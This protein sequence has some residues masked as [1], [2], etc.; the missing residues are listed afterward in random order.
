MNWQEWKDTAVKKAREGVILGG[1][2]LIS[3]LLIAIFQAVPSSVWGRVSE[4][5]PKPVLWALLGLETIAIIGLVPYVFYLRRSASHNLGRGSFPLNL[6][7]Y[8]G[9][10]GILWDKH[11]NAC[12]PICKVLMS[13]ADMKI[14]VFKC[15]KC[16]RSFVLKDELGKP[17][18]PMN[19]KLEV[20]ERHSELIRKVSPLQR[21]VLPDTK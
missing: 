2:S 12:C 17:V 10:F 6:P 13:P 3:F 16:H 1:F 15:P 11:R 7:D 8:I 21:R 9:M 20:A 5:T 4:A 18:N 14:G 19:A